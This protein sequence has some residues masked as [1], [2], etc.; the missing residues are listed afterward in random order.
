MS[1]LTPFRRYL[2][3]DL[4]LLKRCNTVKNNVD[5]GY[6]VESDIVKY[7]R[8]FSLDVTAAILVYQNNDTAAM[9]VYQENPVGIEYFSH[10]KKFFCSNK[11]ARL[12]T[13]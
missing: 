2:L 8:S 9:L 3:K 7:C 6:T 12:L 1:R 4:I 5:V 10:V 11:F 13:T